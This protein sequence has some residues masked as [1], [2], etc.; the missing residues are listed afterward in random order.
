MAIFDW[1]TLNQAKVY[2]DAADRKRMAGQAMGMLAEQPGNIFV[3]HPIVSPQ[4]VI[5]NK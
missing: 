1:S 4:Q 2:T 3:S 5:E